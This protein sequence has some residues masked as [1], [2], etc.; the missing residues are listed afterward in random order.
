MSWR[1]GFTAKGSYK[2]AEFWLRDEELEAGRRKQVHEYP[3][4]DK[5]YVEDLGRATRRYQVEGYVIG[6][7]YHLARDAL[8]AKFEE[9]GSGTLV[10]PYYGRLTVELEKPPRIKQSTRE[11][12][13][14]SISMQFVEAGEQAF[15]T[16][17]VA[18]QGA[19]QTAADQSLADAINA[20]AGVFAISDI[21]GAVDDFLA[22]VDDVF[23]AVANVTGSVSGPLADIIRAPAELGAAIAGAVTN[24]S[25][26]AT[27][28]QRAMAIYGTLF[29]TGTDVTSSAT[30][31]RAQQAARNSQALNELVRTAAVVASCKASAS[32]EL[33]PAKQGDT[34][35]T[36]NA[37]LTLRDSLLD[38]IDTRQQVTDVVSGA[39]IDDAL[40]VSLSDLRVAVM[41]DLSTR[42]KRLP[43]V[44]AFTPRATLPALVIAHRLYGNALRDTELVNLN[45]LRHPGFVQ[46]GVALETLSE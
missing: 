21:A 31:P 9:G 28:P 35:I 15:P 2:G 26:I 38:N 14:A 27:E 22:E 17:T 12:G 40:Y 25:S 24:I 19:V 41:T 18:T 33:S 45:N 6:A 32:L 7:D 1:D 42:G 39:P 44:V 3:L 13:Y 34:P 37:V 10:H 20:F 29:G 46:G 30:A 4:R 43:A 11:G 5:P 36:R 23:A 16:A 8:I